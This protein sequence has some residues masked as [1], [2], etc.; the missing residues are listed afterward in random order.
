MGAG[1]DNEN[2]KRKSV[3]NQLLN[4]KAQSSKTGNVQNV[5][6]EMCMIVNVCC[7]LTDIE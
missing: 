1:D 4:K 3:F 2:E 6:V 5:N 7:L